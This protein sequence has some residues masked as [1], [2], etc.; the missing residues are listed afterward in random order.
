MD[1]E[2]YTPNKK[3]CT[4]E[5]FHSKELGLSKVSKETENQKEDDNEESNDGFEDD[6]DAVQENTVKYI[7]KSTIISKGYRIKFTKGPKRSPTSYHTAVVIASYWTGQNKAFLVYNCKSDDAESR[8]PITVYHSRIVSYENEE[9]IDKNDD[10]NLAEL[11]NEAEK[12]SF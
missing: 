12:G 2:F 11:L 6:A 4:N 1:E 9:E 8:K 10:V 5:N 7:S 3:R